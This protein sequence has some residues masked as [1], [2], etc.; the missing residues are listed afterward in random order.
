L[1]EAGVLE[2]DP[3]GRFSL[4]ALGQRLRSDGPDG[5]RALILG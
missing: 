5:T 3:G 4:S 2:Q 1:A